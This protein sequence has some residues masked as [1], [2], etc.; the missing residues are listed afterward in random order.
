[1]SCW[2][3]ASIV[4][5]KSKLRVLNNRDRSTIIKLRGYKKS[6]MRKIRIVR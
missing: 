6:L 1:L 5:L 4:L 3:M 2:K